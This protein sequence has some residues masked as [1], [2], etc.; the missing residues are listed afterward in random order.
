M[1][2][3]MRSLQRKPKWNMA[4]L[5]AGCI[6]EVVLVGDAFFTVEEGSVQAVAKGTES[7]QSTGASEETLSGSLGENA[8]DFVDELSHGEDVNVSVK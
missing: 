3:G 7:D 8:T 2:R 1:Q 4:V 5:Y 6:C